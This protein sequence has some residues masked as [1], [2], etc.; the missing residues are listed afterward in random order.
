L[1]PDA[2]RRLLGRPT[3]P[4]EQPATAWW[5]TEWLC[6]V[7]RC[8]VLA[9]ASSDLGAVAS[10]HPAV[11]PQDAQG[12][13]A[14]IVDRV[15]EQGWDQAAS[16]G[17]DGVRCSVAAGLLHDPWCR[18]ELAEW[19][20]AGSYCRFAGANRPSAAALLA[21]LRPLLPADV[22]EAVHRILSRWDLGDRSEARERSRR[23]PG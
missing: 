13:T 23:H 12:A 20:D 1:V 22:A 3:P 17:W 18:A 10:L 15:V 4:P 11:D 8:L 5:A 16:T 7:A 19:Y 6:E 2:A 21:A 14:D 9:D